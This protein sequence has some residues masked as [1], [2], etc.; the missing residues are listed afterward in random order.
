MYSTLYLLKGDFTDEANPATTNA[1]PATA[2][3]CSLVLA[4]TFIATAATRIIDTT[5]YY[6]HQ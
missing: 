3:P 5:T 2:T 1:G 6:C 4:S